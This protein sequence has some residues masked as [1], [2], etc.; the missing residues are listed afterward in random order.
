[1]PRFTLSHLGLHCAAISCWPGDTVA[2][3]LCCFLTPGQLTRI[4][5]FLSYFLL[6]LFSELACVGGQMDASQFVMG[7]AEPLYINLNVLENKREAYF[8]GMLC[9][10]D[11]ISWFLFHNMEKTEFIVE[12]IIHP[13]GKKRK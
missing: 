7:V 9:I 11:N 2:W 6:L 8:K 3:E 1:M 10:I 13:S 4:F 12:H 5:S